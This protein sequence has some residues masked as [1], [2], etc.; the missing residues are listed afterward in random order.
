MPQVMPA[1]FF[2][3][4]NPMN[5]LLRKPHR[6]LGGY[7]GG[8]SASQGYPLRIGSLVH[9]G[10]CGDGEHRPEHDPRL[11]WVPA[12][13]YRVQHPRARRF[14]RLRFTSRT[15]SP[16][17]RCGRMTGGGWT[18]ARGRSC[19]TCTLRR[20]FRSCSLA[21]TR[22]SLPRSTARSASVPRRLS[23]LLGFVSTD[24]AV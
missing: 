10:R 14:P 7:R 15:C 19:A 5:A 18:T 11:R 13:L 17:C 21:S 20:T 12:E 23:V 9:R 6:K 16:Q 8:D 1:V 2:G 22:R 4:G 24:A 3:H